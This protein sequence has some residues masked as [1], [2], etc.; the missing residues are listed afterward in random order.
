MRSESLALLEYEG[1]VDGGCV[2]TVL[3]TQ[4]RLPDSMDTQIVYHPCSHAG[5][6]V[7]LDILKVK[8]KTKIIKTF[9]TTPMGLS[10]P[11]ENEV[12]GATAKSVALLDITL[13]N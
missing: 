7:L 3:C 2:L 8:F 12:S 5:C 10:D 1:S 11:Y 4:A 13:F 6:M 9:Q